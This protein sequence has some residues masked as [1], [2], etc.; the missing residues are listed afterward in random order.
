MGEQEDPRVTRSRGRILES[1]RTVFLREGYLGTTLDQVAVESGVAKRTIYNLYADKDDLFRA[2]ILSAIEIADRFAASIAADVVEVDSVEDL[3]SI[4]ERLAEATLLGPA[5]PLRR[6]L[7]MESR[8]FPD[9]VS[10]YRRRAPEAVMS[11]LSELFR[12]AGR[13][14]SLDIRDP[15]LAAEHFAFLIMGADLDRGMFT[16]QHPPRTAVTALARDGAEAFL[17]AYRVSD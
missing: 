3:P 4:A 1:A 9:L 11:A 13:A 8:R 16:G 17:R 14:G 2:T 5:L 15:R 7:V 10:E 12:R 6:L